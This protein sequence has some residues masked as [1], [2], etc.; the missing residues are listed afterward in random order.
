MFTKDCALKTAAATLGVILQMTP[1]FAQSYGAGGFS[2]TGGY[3]NSQ[4]TGTS[5]P[6]SAYMP[7]G[8]TLSASL[9]TSISTEAAKPGDFVQATLTQPVTLAE[10]TVP[11]GTV[12]EGHVVEAKAGGFLGR[13]GRLT[14]KF[15]RL[16]TPSGATAQLAAHIVGNLGNYKQVANGSETF[17]GEGIGTKVGQTLVRGA[18][19]AG[20]GAALGTAVG[21]I[22]GRGQR[23]S[24]R[25]VYGPYGHGMYPV[26]Y[27]PQ[28]RS[29]A[30]MGAGRGAWSGAAIGGG[31]GVADALLIR[32]GKNI[33]IP[34][35]TQVQL[36]LDAPTT[37]H[38]NP[39]G[40]YGGAV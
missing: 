12:L 4:P 8:M 31:L 11:A 39:Q 29:G 3:S 9:A 5:S 36:Q 32:K 15:D 6:G 25:P 20:A 22:A 7:A 14:V 16:R 38:R 19:G 28:V 18:I 21:A 10:G 27:A 2:N 17:A 37:I 35:G 33:V 13:S 40:G 23:V 24:Y 30:A 26:G 34:T 1:A